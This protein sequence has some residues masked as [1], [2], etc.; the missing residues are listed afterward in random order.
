L[1]VLT[2]K[3]DRATDPEAPGEVFDLMARL[4]HLLLLPIK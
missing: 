2:H 4:M 1:S 3:P